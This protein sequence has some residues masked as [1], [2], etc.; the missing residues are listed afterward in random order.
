[1]TAT[2][3]DSTNAA[4]IPIDAA[5]VAGYVNGE[6]AWSPEDWARFTAASKLGI[7]VKN[8]GAGGALDIEKGDAD[9][10]DAPSWVA[11]RHAAGI[12]RPWLYIDRE[13]WQALHDELIASAGRPVGG[14]EWGY[15]VADWTGEPHELELPDGTKADA[16]QYADPATSGGHFDLTAIYGPLPAVG[17]PAPEPTT[18]SPA[19]APSEGNDDV[20]VPTIEN[21]S[22]GGAVK[23][24]QSILNGKAGARLAVDGD[25]GP[26]TEAAVKAWQQFFRLEVDGIVGPQTWATLLDG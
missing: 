3:Y 1:M 10:P 16:V 13:N 7:D 8:A 2:M 4:D 5:A 18:P 24:A 25:F 12:G 17:A 6:F 15:W 23:A 19:P 22:K 9:I 11:N 14:L 21:G 26:A 20:N